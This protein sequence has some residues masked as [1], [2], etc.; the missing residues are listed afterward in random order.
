MADDSPNPIILYD[1]V[2][3]LCNRIVQFILKR[4]SRDRF[5]FATLQSEF[6]RRLLQKHA[7]STENLETVYLL[8]DHAQ[9]SEQ[10][11]VRSAASITIFR[12]LGPFW[13]ALANLFA[14]LPRGLRD[15]GYTLIARYR[16]PIFGKYETCPL[17]NPSHRHKFLEVE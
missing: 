15:W 2:C 1:G 9:P 7:A 6:A 14:I 13:R 16:Y 8:L 5:R 17:P 3:G 4:D 12:E 10:L 11:L